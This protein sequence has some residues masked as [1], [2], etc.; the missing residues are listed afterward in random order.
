MKKE[1]NKKNYP[2]DLSDTQWNIINP[3]IPEARPGGR[4]R[5]VNIRLII[6]A[7][8]YVLI[9]GCQWRMLPKDFPAWQ[10]V[11]GYFRRWEKD[12]TWKNIHNTLYT[13]LRENNGR[14]ITPSVG[15]IDSQSV[16]T[17]ETPSPRGYDAGKKV[18]G[19]KRHILVDSIG[20]LIEAVVHPADIQDRDGAKLVFTRLKKDKLPRLKTIFADGG[21]SGSLIFWALMYLGITLSIV[22]KTKKKMKEIKYY[23]QLL[24]FGKVSETEIKKNTNSFEVL[25]WR[26]IVERTLA[27]ISRNRRLSKDYEGLNNVSE[28]FIYL[29]MIKVMIRRL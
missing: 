28:A 19:K 25:P 16:K 21:Y 18:K 26:W 10:T 4:P 17:T 24:L 6:N 1:I 23:G 27:W 20:L 9:S 5:I 12:G 2:S 29:A 11:Y 22:R 14:K 13:V 8:F 15:I 7:I 3:L